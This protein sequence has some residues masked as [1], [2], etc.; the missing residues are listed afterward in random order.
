MRNQKHV[1]HQQRDRA[2]IQPL[3]QDF[4]YCSPALQGD[5]CQQRA[6]GNAKLLKKD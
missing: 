1:Q 5:F 2:I 6:V 4:L 3:S